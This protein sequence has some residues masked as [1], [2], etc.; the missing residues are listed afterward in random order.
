MN[1]VIRVKDF[2]SAVDFCL[3]GVGKDKNRPLTAKLHIV[4]SEGDCYMES[5]NGEILTRY[6]LPVV[7]EGEGFDFMMSPIKYTTSNNEAE[8][9]FHTREDGTVVCVRDGLAG[10]KVT[11]TVSTLSEKYFNTNLL[12]KQRDDACERVKY[13]FD[14]KVLIK[15]LRGFAKEESV[16]LYVPTNR[17]EAWYVNDRKEDNLIGILMPMRV[18]D[19]NST[20]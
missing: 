11:E 2:N 5:C 4:A 16:D 6:R 20:S 3:N 10:D 12:W 14:P 19:D 9:L 13:T 8:L 15:G 18:E 17:N 7:Y 1:F